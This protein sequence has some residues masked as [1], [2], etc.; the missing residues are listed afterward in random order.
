MK[1]VNLSEFLNLPSGTV[2]MKYEPCVFQDL[3]VK[4]DSITATNDFLYCSITCGIECTSGND[5]VDKLFAAEDN[6]T[7]V[8][9]NFDIIRRDGC[10]EAGQLFAVYEKEDV[11]QLIAKLGVCLQQYKKQE[12]G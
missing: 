11:E 2:Y 7:S 6:N 9:L 1:I 8:G 10:F 5:M 3:C 12:Q 4:D